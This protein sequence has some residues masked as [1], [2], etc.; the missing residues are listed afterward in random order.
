MNKGPN[1]IIDP[2]STCMDD[3]VLPLQDPGLLGLEDLDQSDIAT[4]ADAAAAA[5]PPEIV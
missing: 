2:G 4:W 5:G 1:A 3:R